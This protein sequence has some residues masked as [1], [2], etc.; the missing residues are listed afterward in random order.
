MITVVTK[1]FEAH[2]EQIES[3]TVVDSSGWRNEGR[4]LTCRFLRP[5]TE[6]EVADFQVKPPAAASKKTVAK[7]TSKKGKKRTRKGP[8]QR[9]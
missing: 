5:A 3:G 7:Q 1:A 2:G 9:R 4:L 6:D 8:Q